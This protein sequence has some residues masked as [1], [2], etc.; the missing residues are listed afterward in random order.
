ML[1]EAKGREH[2]IREKAMAFAEKRFQFDS[3]KR[4]LQALPETLELAEAKK[5]P[6]LTEYEENIRFNRMIRAMFGYCPKAHP[7]ERAGGQR[8]AG[9]QTRAG[10]APKA[11]AQAAAAERQRI[12]D[13][14][15]G[16]QPPTPSSQYYEEYREAKAEEEAE[17]ERRRREREKA[18]QESLAQARK[19]ERAKRSRG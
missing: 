13:E 4:A 2:E 18:Y 3:A 12:S 8:D 14:L 7:E 17:E 10:G 6:A 5:D 19:S 9:G 15:G 16:A 11:A 1:R